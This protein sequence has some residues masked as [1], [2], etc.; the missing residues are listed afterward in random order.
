[1][2]PF[3]CKLS[4]IGEKWKR[5]TFRRDDVGIANLWNVILHTVISRAISEMF[6][7]A[8]CSLNAAAIA[9]ETYYRCMINRVDVSLC[10]CDLVARMI[11]EALR[12]RFEHKPRFFVNRFPL[13]W[14]SSEKYERSY[15]SKFS[16]RSMLSDWAAPV[17]R[18]KSIHNCV[19]ET[20][21]KSRASEYDIA[22]ILCNKWCNFQL[23]ILDRN[24]NSI[25]PVKVDFFSKDLKKLYSQNFDVNFYFLNLQ[26]FNYNSP[27]FF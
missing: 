14:R 13:A 12:K 15:V 25:K 6:I 10:C 3:T 23:L 22:L 19:N 26:F 18:Q 11:N 2:E 4:Y 5:E 7:A 16:A 9:P 20:A 1:M 27:G 8:S 17:L 21:R 24:K